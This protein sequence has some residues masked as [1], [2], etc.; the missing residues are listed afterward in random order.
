MDVKQH[1]PSDGLAFL[2]R[3]NMGDLRRVWKFSLLMSVKC[4]HLRS[5]AVLELRRLGLWYSQQS[6]A[7][8][9]PTSAQ[10]TGKSFSKRNCSCRE[11]S[12]WNS[13][14]HDRFVRF[15]PMN[16]LTVLW[17][18]LRVYVSVKFR[19]SIQLSMSST[20]SKYSEQADTNWN[21]CRWLPAA[22]MS[23]TFPAKNV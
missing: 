9:T 15:W 7:L 18:V 12:L 17:R 1:T 4:M 3:L 20:L 10:S 16:L 21:S 11:E 2:S 14:E 5:L 19:I 13:D 8:R 23:W 22:K 6:T